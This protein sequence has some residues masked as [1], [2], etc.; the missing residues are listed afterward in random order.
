MQKTA[1]TLLL[2][3]LRKRPYTSYT[4]EN[5]YVIKHRLIIL[6]AIS[7]SIRRRFQRILLNFDKSRKRVKNQRRN[8]D[9]ESSLNRN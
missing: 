5:I 2:K 3:K 4:E 6:H 1:K 9:V 7:T 8:F